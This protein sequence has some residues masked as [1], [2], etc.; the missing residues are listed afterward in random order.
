MYTI[1]TRKQ[2]RKDFKRFQNTKAKNIQVFKEVVTLLCQRKD[3]P[4]ARRDHALIGNY[5][6]C[7][8]CHL[9]P[10]WLLVYIVDE[11]QKEIILIRI[12]SH[13]ELF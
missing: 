11:E 3:L 4:I 1:S 7:R 9:A 12:G 13:N 10:D 8:E 5:R 2:Y 6:G